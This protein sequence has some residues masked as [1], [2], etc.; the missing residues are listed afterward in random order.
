M[1]IY[2]Y[3]YIFK[4]MYTYIRIKDELGLIRII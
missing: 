4:D 3:I 1:Y 2:T